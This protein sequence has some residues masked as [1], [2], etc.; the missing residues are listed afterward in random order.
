MTQKDAILM[1]KHRVKTN[2]NRARRVICKDQIEQLHI[3]AAIDFYI[4][5]LNQLNNSLEYVLLQ[6][7]K[8]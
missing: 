8:H 2:L 7:S 3:Q 5:E 4:T 6:E 1:E